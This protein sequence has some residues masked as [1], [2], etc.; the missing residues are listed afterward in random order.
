MLLK[1]E[2]S[3]NAE[4]ELGLFN[5]VRLYLETKE[6]INVRLGDRPDEAGVSRYAGGRIIRP[7]ED[8]QGLNTA[9]S[10]TRKINTLWD[11]LWDS[12]IHLE[13]IYQGVKA[14]LEKNSDVFFHCR[15]EL[16]PL[17]VEKLNVIQLGDVLLERTFDER[18]FDSTLSRVKV[19]EE[20]IRSIKR[21]NISYAFS[22]STYHP[23]TFPVAKTTN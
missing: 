16:N 7:I 14:S 15:V 20:Y 18:T 17:I 1:Y 23:T 3:T 13:G 21:I 10:A 22:Y 19:T 11:E 5:R 8:Y 9:Y 2:T 12:N 4:V 6:D